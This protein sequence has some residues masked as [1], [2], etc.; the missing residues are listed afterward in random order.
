MLG[1]FLSRKLKEVE[2]YRVM[3]GHAPIY[4]RAQSLGFFPNLYENSSHLGVVGGGGF[5]IAVVCFAS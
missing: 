4:V 5:G 3:Y 2:H 1:I